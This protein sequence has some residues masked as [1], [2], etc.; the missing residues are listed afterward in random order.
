MYKLTPDADQ[1]KRRQTK[2]KQITELLRLQVRELEDMARQIGGS[3]FAAITNDLVIALNS[4]A[5]AI[6]NTEGDFEQAIA[7]SRQAVATRPNDSALLDTLAHCY[8]A[9]GRWADAVEQ[10]R[11]AVELKPHSPTMR[12]AL[13]RFE[14]R[15]QTELKHTP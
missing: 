4:Y 10:Q 2:H 12:K 14:E 6:A 13:A 8:F 11:K 3:Q 9:A 5:W 1:A 7:F 15:L